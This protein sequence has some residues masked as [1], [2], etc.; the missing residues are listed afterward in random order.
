[1]PFQS[2]AQRRYMFAKHPEIANRWVNE[3]KSKGVS[4]TVPHAPEKK[5]PT[6]K[7][8][9]RKKGVSDLNVNAPSRTEGFKNLAAATIKQRAESRRT[10]IVKPFSKNLRKI[11]E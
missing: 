4:A 5:N 3:A 11:A 1:M 10:P 9:F 7:V 2:E 8:G 6:E